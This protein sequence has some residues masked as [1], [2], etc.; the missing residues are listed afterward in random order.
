MEG[1]K[2]GGT[3]KGSEWKDTRVDAQESGGTGTH[4]G[5]GKGT[6]RTGLRDIREEAQVREVSGWTQEW[7]QRNVVA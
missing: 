7:T 6:E 5:P 1:H 4:T 3:G 2:R